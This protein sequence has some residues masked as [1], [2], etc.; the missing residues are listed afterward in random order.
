[1]RSVLLKAFGK[2]R[3][4]SPTLSISTSSSL[5]F[6]SH[7]PTNSTPQT[8]LFLWPF[9][10]TV[11]AHRISTEVIFHRQSH[12]ECSR[13]RNSK[14]ERLLRSHLYKSRSMRQAPHGNRCTGRHTAAKMHDA[15]GTGASWYNGQTWLLFCRT[16]VQDGPDGAV[17]SLF[18]NPE[19]QEHKCDGHVDTL[20]ALGLNR[21]SISMVQFRCLSSA[22][23]HWQDWSLETCELRFPSIQCV[24]PKVLKMCRQS[25]KMCFV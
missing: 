15:C 19:S 16:A 22:L 24:V 2:H 10:R 14:K 25:V 20:S 11:S 5:W 4:T 23:Q 13:Q 3:L 18:R 17:V 7:W 21:L 1:M 6:P 9:C 8:G 12:F